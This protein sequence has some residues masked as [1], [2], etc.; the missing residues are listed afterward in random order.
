MMDES[1]AISSVADI[2]TEMFRFQRVFTKAIRNAD[3]EE[4]NKYVSQFN[5]F[6]K[7]VYK[8]LD[9]LSLSIVNVEE[10]PYDPGM[11]VTPLNLDDFDTDDNLMVAQMIE[12][13]IMCGDQLIKTGTVMLGRAE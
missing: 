12:P 13:I 4:R 8:A 6:Q 7:K 9:E 5:W 10:Q 11:A 2:A 3:L 1:K